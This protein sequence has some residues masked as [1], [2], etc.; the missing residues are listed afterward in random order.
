MTNDW[1]SIRPMLS[2]LPGG[3]L[4]VFAFVVADLL[5]VQTT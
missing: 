3:L 2:G 5:S 4:A 1:E